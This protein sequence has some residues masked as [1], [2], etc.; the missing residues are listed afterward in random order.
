MV[1]VTMPISGARRRKS[2]PSCRVRLATD[3]SCRSSQSKPIGKAGDV[4][5]VDPRAD[6]ATALADRLQGQGHEIAHDG[7]D[8]RS[9]ERL[10]G[11]IS[12][13]PPAQAA[14]RPRAKV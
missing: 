8:D 14:P 12:S 5:H 10:S 9:V 4:A 1:W 11:G 3:A 2:N 6:D 7:K 13:D